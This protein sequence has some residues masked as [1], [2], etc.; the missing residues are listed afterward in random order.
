[1]LFVLQCLRAITHADKS[2]GNK[3]FICV[4]LRLYVCLSVRTIE[5]KKLKLQL[6]MRDWKNRHGQ[7]CRAEKCRSGNIGTVLQGV[8]NAGV[9]YAGVLSSLYF[10]TYMCLYLYISA[11][12]VKCTKRSNQ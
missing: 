12:F 7:N 6:K 9:E 10:C 5:P 11:S 4:C 3:A 1:M 2:C 8:E